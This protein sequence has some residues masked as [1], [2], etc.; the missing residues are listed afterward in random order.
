M[1]KQKTKDAKRLEAFSQITVHCPKC[2]HSIP[3]T[4]RSDFKICNWCGTKTYKNKE[5]EFREKLKIA[6]IRSKKND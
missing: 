6:Q 3:M 4:T 2:G 1:S 5:I